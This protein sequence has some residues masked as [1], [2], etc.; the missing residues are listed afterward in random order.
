MKVMDIFTNFDYIVFDAMSSKYSI[1]DL[2]KFIEYKDIPK[3]IIR[4]WNKKFIDYHFNSL[5]NLSIKSNLVFDYRGYSPREMVLIKE[6]F[7]KKTEIVPNTFAFGECTFA[8][9]IKKVG[10]NN[11]E[12]SNVY[13]NSESV[14]SNFIKYK[15]M[16]EATDKHIITFSNNKNGISGSDLSSLRKMSS[17][18]MIFLSKMN[19][20]VLSKN[21]RSMIYALSFENFYNLKL[22]TKNDIDK[23]LSLGFNSVAFIDKSSFSKYSLSWEEYIYIS[24]VSKYVNSFIFG[25]PFDFYN[26]ESSDLARFN[27]I[28]DNENFKKNITNIKSKNIN[29]VFFIN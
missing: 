27:W 4:R 15:S 8:P 5:K 3:I 6:F 9:W 16:I 20:V 28:I 18:D 12:W 1:S 11:Y 25:I 29:R 10:S 19:D 7:E 17:T 22:I 23:I 14:V 2:D 24:K 26:K 13:E 21:G